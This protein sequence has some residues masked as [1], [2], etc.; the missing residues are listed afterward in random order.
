VRHVITQ[1]RMQTDERHGD[2]T[3]TPPVPIRRAG[4]GSY[5]DLERLLEP[6]WAAVLQ[7]EFSKPYWSQLKQA[8]NAR[9]AAGEQ[10]LPP[11]HLIFAAFDQCP[12]AQTV[13]LLC[14]QDPYIGPGQAEGLAFSVPKGVAVP[15]SLRTIYRE[16]EADVPGFVTPRHGHLGAWARQGVLLLNC[17]LTVAAGR[18]NSHAGL[19]WQLFTDA[20]VAALNKRDQRVPTTA[21][22]LPTESSAMAFMDDL[23]SAPK[24]SPSSTAVGTSPSSSRQP[25]NKPLVALL[26]GAAAKAKC[27]GID[28]SRHCVLEAGHPSPLNTSQPFAGCRHFSKAN[29]FLRT[30]QQPAIDWRL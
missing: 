14:A 23:A 3:P 30:Q 13:A 19:G 24:S 11:R 26:W 16:L 7:P 12:F 17:S 1:K 15:P 2:K 4:R 21:A 28:R 22:A 27:K 8:L 25:D 6:S 29:A 9:E 5:D 20:V 18:S 10:I